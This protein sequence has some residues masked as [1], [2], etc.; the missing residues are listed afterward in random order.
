MNKITLDTIMPKGVEL[1]KIE[2]EIPKE[3]D[4]VYLPESALNGKIQGISETEDVIKFAV[5]FANAILRSFEDGKISL[6][7]LPYYFN[8]ALKLPS[9]LTGIN[10]VPAEIADLT[11]SELQQLADIV[12]E[13]LDVTNAK[14]K[15][16]VQ[17]SLNLIYAI[18]DLVNTIKV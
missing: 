7:D 6:M 10:N 4:P 12:V 2:F 11:M 16:I 8:V 1:Q 14:A 17:K 15:I 18:W 3:L 13:E 5:A 9:A